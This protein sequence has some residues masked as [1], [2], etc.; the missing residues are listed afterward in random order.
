MTFASK[1][2]SLPV[3][4]S[5]VIFLSFLLYDG[6]EEHL[7]FLQ[8][9]RSL[10]VTTCRQLLHRREA[11]VS[12]SSER[13]VGQCWKQWSIIEQERRV[14]Y[15]VAQFECLQSVVFDI[16]ATMVTRELIRPLPCHESLWACSNPH[17]WKALIQSCECRNTSCLSMNTPVLTYPRPRPR[18]QRGVNHLRWTAYRIAGTGS[19]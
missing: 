1:V 12:S 13:D 6:S 15:M 2:E 14:I 7:L 19:E 4:Q 5:V 10:L 9:H 3:I 8:H 11:D 16:P 17:D 18:Y